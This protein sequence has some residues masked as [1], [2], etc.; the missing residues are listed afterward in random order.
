M[1]TLEDLRA[2]DPRD[3]ADSIAHVVHALIQAGRLALE[4]D[5]SGKTQHCR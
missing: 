1:I 5:N 4:N 3:T 2:G